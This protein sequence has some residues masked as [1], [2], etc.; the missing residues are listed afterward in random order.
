LRAKTTPGH[1]SGRLFGDGPTC[2]VWQVSHNLIKK[3]RVLFKKRKSLFVVVRACLYFGILK[4][5]FKRKFSQRNI[6]VISIS[7][8]IVGLALFRRRNIKRGYKCNFDV[9]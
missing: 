9:L 4:F 7:A 2:G 1:H 3:A 8:A 6:S 5:Y